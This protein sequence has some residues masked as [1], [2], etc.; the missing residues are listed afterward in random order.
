MA[1]GTQTRPVLVL[2][3]MSVVPLG[4]P[5]IVGPVV[6]TTL[7]LSA[8]IQRYGITLVPCSVNL[9]LVWTALRWAHKIERAIA[10][11]GACA[12]AKGC[13]LAVSLGCRG[14]SVALLVSPSEMR[15]LFNEG[16][17]I[18]K[19]HSKCLDASTGEHFRRQCLLFS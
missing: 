12:V 5:V 9:V 7:L 8:R 4:I 15:L 10:E 1:T 14:R 2:V 18:K 16:N 3:R 11:A 13:K 17:K 19:S 6:L